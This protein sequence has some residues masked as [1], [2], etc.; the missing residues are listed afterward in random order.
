MN[1]QWQVLIQDIYTENNRSTI[2][3]DEKLFTERELC[4]Y[5]HVNRSLLREALVALETLGVIDIRE[6]RG[7]FLENEPTKMLSDSLDFMNEYS[8]TLLH[9]QSI[10]ARMIIEPKS[11]RMATQNCTPQQS[12]I[13]WNEMQ[14]LH[15]LYDNEKMDIQEK[16]TLAYRHNIIIY[17]T[18]HRRSRGTRC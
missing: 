2:V 15:D 12:D 18:Q 11:A 6:R 3:K 4:E 8:L 10:E 16:A 5:F 13:L 7:S 9:D 14:F 17:Y 1:E